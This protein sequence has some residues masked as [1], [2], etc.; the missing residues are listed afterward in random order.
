MSSVSGRFVYPFFGPY[1]S[2]KFALEAYT[3]ALRRELLLSGIHVASIEPGSIDTPIW[4][5]AYAHIERIS[6]GYPPEAFGRYH[7]Y[8]K[9]YEKRKTRVGPNGLP[10][11]T[12]VDA[13]NHALVANRP[14][15]R[16]RIGRSA[17]MMIFL[18][19]FVPDKAFDYFVKRAISLR[20]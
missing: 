5:T 6:E 16:Y 3:D 8:F 4:G 13:V 15:T 20:R 19:R 10:P 2:S 14:K 9:W 7:T 18:S 17:R 11:Q 12:V 1:A